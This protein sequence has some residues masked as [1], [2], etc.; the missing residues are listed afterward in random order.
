MKFNKSNSPINQSL[1]HY[2]GI[3]GEFDYDPSIWE[4][5]NNHLIFKNKEVK[6]LPKNLELPKCCVDISYMIFN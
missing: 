1:I 6:S 3:L 2:A 4:I 5:V